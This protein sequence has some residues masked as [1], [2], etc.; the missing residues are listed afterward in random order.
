MPIM[1]AVFHE[2]LDVCVVVYIDDILIYSKNEDDPVW[3][4]RHVLKKLQ[5]QK[6]LAN[7]K[8]REF[9]LNKLDFLGHML[10]EENIRLDLKKIS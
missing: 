5:Q 3:D 2:E 6:W 10:N 4:L 8:N 9:T 1:N 7:A